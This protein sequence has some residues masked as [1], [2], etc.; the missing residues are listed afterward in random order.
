[1]TFSVVYGSTA[2]PWGMSQI[3]YN[4]YHPTLP[5]QTS[6]Q[7]W[8]VSWSLNYLS[9]PAFSGY[10]ITADITEQ[11]SGQH[12][13]WSFAQNIGPVQIFRV[14]TNTTL[15]LVAYEVFQNGSIAPQVQYRDIL[16]AQAGRTSGLSFDQWNSYASQVTHQ[17]GPT[18][19]AVCLDPSLEGSP[20][21]VDTY[22]SY[23]QNRG[24]SCSTDSW[25]ELSTVEALANCFPSNSCGLNWNEWGLY[26]TTAGLGQPP[27][28]SQACMPLV[29]GI[30]ANQYVQYTSRE[31]Y[32]LVKY[33]QGGDAL[34]VIPLARRAAHNQRGRC[35]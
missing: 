6:P 7:N 19:Q 32:A 22:L 29:S 35:K 30:Y 18:P 21:T 17:P 1:M 25:P 10:V 9:V 20:I 33:V 16:I 34:R 2:P 14:D 4:C 13:Q 23:L 3:D 5:N 11:Y 31:W 27:A 12:E 8:I 24:T 28:P 26:Y 15:D